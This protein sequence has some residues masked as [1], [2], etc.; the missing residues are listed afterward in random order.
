MERVYKINIACNRCS[1]LGNTDDRGAE[2]T[3][4]LRMVLAL[5]G[6]GIVMLGLNVSL[7]GIVTMGWQGSTDFVAITDAAAFQVQD[8]HVRFIAGVW[9]GVGLLF[10]AGA[11]KL[12]TMRPIMG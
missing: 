11:A 2:M 7:G 9:T 1:L 5:C 3:N 10:L 12:E 8:N 6:I 4:L